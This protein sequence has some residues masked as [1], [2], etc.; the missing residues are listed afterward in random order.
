MT[1]KHSLWHD[2]VTQQAND[3]VI[4]ALYLEDDIARLVRA[5]T[6]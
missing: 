5:S 1:Q 4:R 3:A 2:N 6:R